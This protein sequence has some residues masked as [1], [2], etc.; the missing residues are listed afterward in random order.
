MEDAAGCLS[1][2]YTASYGAYKYW[3]IAAFIVVLSNVFFVELVEIYFVLSVRL[4]QWYISI[5]NI[6][7]PREMNWGVIKP[8]PVWYLHLRYFN[9]CLLTVIAMVEA[10]EFSCQKSL[11]Q[12][13]FSINVVSLFSGLLKISHAGIWYVSIYGY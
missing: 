6:Y 5:S 9:D 13:D 12:I 11:L 10:C 8:L 1:M 2:V 4:I 3:K 7:H